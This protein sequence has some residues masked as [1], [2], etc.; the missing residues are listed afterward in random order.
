MQKKMKDKEL[1]VTW[2][3]PDVLNLHGD[4]G[5]VM[6]LEKIG[7][8]L[9]LDV[10]ITR[11][12]SYSQKIDF[13][14]TDIIMINPG[15]VKVISKI[16]EV[17][18]A[19]KEKMDRYVEDGKIILA[20]GTSGAVMAKKI[21]F[22]NNTEIDGLGYLNMEAIQRDTVY[23][24]DV[25]YTLKEEENI[26]IAGNQIQLMDVKINSECALGKVDYG[27]GNNGDGTEGAKYKNVIFT[28][29]LGPVLVKNP[30]YTENLIRKAMKTKNVEL[31]ENKLDYELEM[32]SLECI[33]NFISRKGE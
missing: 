4:R 28:N 18:N 11:V 29:A 12:D 6:A 24:N 1:N 20:I 7:K 17:L 23:G 30:W 5:N 14:N 10:N 2:L 21:K 9:G 27:R 22:L 8:I 16:V 32:K 33:K 25:L 13:D 15:E 19:Q 3:Y 26:Q 31:E